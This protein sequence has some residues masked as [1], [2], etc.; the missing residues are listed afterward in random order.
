MRDIIFWTSVLFTVANWKQKTNIDRERWPVRAGIF[1]PAINDWFS[2]LTGDGSSSIDV[3]ISP[4][5]QSHQSSPESRPRSWRVE[6]SGTGLVQFNS[7]QSLFTFVRRETHSE[8]VRFSSWTHPTKSHDKQNGGARATKNS[9]EI[10]VLRNGNT[11]IFA[12]HSVEKTFRMSNESCISPPSSEFR[13]RWSSRN[14]GYI[15]IRKEGRPT[16]ALIAE[17]II[18]EH[19]RR[20]YC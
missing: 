11:N 4:V 8:I 19:S 3:P 13:F 16:S 14:H 6:G 17:S 1:E 18:Q 2:P 9:Q 20:Y 5:S 10:C 12:Y 7:I 15:D